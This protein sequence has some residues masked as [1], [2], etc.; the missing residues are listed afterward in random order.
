M[1]SA[2]QLNIFNETMGRFSALFEV[3]QED[4]FDDKSIKT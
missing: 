2:T 4:I 1:V 3:K